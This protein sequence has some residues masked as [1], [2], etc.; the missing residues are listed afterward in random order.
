[1]DVPN[2]KI[3]GKEIPKGLMRDK[4]IRLIKNKTNIVGQNPKEK[5]TPSKNA[6]IFSFARNSIDKISKRNI[7]IKFY[8]SYYY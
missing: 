2:A 8:V 7:F 3:D 6:P 5:L 4:G 1:M